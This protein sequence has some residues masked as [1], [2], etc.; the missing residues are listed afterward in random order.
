[1][2]VRRFALV[3]ALVKAQKIISACLLLRNAYFFTKVGLQHWCT[4][5]LKSFTERRVCLLKAEVAEDEPRQFL[6]RD[7]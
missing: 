2:H 5:N 6:S 3:F 4:T 7:E 1:M